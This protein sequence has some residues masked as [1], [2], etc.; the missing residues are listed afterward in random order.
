MIAVAVV[1]FASVILVLVG[2]AWTAILTIFGG[3]LIGV[4]L[5]GI[6]QKI[7]D[8]TRMPRLLALALVLLAMLGA[9]I[10]VLIWIGP[11]LAEHF[12]GLRQ[13]ITITWQALRS[14]LQA[15]TW[16]S[17][18]YAE[19]S[20]MEIQSLLTPRFGGFL[21]TTVGTIGALLLIAVFGLYFAVD[22]T[23]YLR[24]TARLF[25]PDRRD[26]VLDLFRAIGRALRSWFVGRFLSMV[27]VGA[28][29]AIGLWAVGVPLAL[30]LG[31][32]A[33]VLSFVPNLGPMIS[34]VPGVLVGLSVDPRTALWALLVYVGVQII[35]SYVITPLIQQRVVSMP[36]ALL[37][38][39]QLLMGLSGGIIGL[40]MATPLLVAIVVVVQSLYL[41]DALHDDVR[42]IGE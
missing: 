17:R 21:S 5:D 4:L 42:V 33:G 34:A 22:P 6:A 2:L 27:V 16:G 13:Q 26:R 12:E 15:R 30:P 23:L 28:G 11:A 35:E 7:A 10:G 8:W 9:T 31:I 37:L 29:T 14:W 36:P 39:F 38:A 25:P 3:V 41:R 40:F 32:L 24:G 1:A 19:L 20:N 18:L